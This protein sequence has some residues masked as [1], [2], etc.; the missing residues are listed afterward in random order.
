MSVSDKFLILL[1]IGSHFW[2]K[3]MIKEVML[4]RLGISSDFSEVHQEEFLA[5]EN[6]EGS[7]YAIDFYCQD[8]K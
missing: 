6:S 8:V 3:T 5:L 1:L 4:C 2:Y 7:I